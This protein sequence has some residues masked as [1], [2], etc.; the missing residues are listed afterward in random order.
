M[1]ISFVT[2]A[3]FHF[4]DTK[5]D[6][7]FYIRE[8]RELIKRYARQSHA[9]KA[10]QTDGSKVRFARHPPATAKIAIRDFPARSLSD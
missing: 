6:A 10:A 9:P 5:N 7:S 8:E 1:T 4:Q 3:S 2:S